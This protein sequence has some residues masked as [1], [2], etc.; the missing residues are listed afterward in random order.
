LQGGTCG[1]KLLCDNTFSITRKDEK[2]YGRRLNLAAGSG[3]SSSSR[4]VSKQTQ[5]ASESFDF[6]E[7]RFL[8]QVE[9]HG[10][11]GHAQ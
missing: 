5:P 4:S 9:T 1:K 10:Q 11:Q 7:N 3:G 2:Q 8:H 6:H